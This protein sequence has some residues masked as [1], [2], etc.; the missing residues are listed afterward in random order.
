MN[1]GV[2]LVPVGSIVVIIAAVY[3]AMARIIRLRASLPESASG[4]VAARLE[5]GT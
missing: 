5:A 3:V 4:D 2:F 1:P